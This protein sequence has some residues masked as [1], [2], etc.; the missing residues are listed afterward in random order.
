LYR[1]YL[2]K[3]KKKGRELHFEKLPEHFHLSYN[4]NNTSLWYFVEYGN[5][6]KGVMHLGLAQGD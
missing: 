1:N 6:K 4:E 5:G 3:A 2:K